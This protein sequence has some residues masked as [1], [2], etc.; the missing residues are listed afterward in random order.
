MN[1]AVAEKI[2]LVICL[3]SLSEEG[4]LTVHVGNVQ[5]E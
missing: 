2:K 1:Q 4:S 3:D 5:T